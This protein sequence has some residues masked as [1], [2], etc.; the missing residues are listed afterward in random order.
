MTIEEAN[1]LALRAAETDDVAGIAEALQAR[2]EA[3]RELADAAPSEQLA[4]RIA[5]TLEAG[6]EIRRALL[7]IKHRARLQNARLAQLKT[8]FAAGAASVRRPQVDCRG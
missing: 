2:A 6:N 7:A 1:E 8:G 5:G 4:A 3:I